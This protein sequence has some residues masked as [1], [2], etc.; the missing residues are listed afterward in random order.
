MITIILPQVVEYF[1]IGT[2][3][4]QGDFPNDFSI[5]AQLFAG[6]TRP[7]T[8]LFATHFKEGYNLYPTFAAPSN[9]PAFPDS[10]SVIRTF[11]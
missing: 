10:C 5:T 1:F 8:Q 9:H 7:K 11:R 2:I 3:C 4:P 6:K